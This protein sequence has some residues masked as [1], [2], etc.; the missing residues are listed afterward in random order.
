MNN[1]HRFK[2]YEAL[3][4]FALVT[5]LFY[6][7]QLERVVQGPQ[8]GRYWVKLKKQT[9]PRCQLPYRLKDEA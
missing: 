6:Y 8:N 9:Q 2:I 5:C 7:A 3:F 1:S 4:L